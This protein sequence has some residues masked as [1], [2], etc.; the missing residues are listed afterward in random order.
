MKVAVLGGGGCF[1]LNFVSHLDDNSIEHFGIGRSLEK[2]PAFWQVSHHYRYRALHLSFNREAICAVLDTER[3]DIVV[4]F[5]AQGEG[6]ASFGENAPDYFQTNTVALV[7]LVCEL[8]KRNYLKRFIQIGSSEVYG[9]P[10]APARET[11]LLNPTSP[12]SV[13]KAAFDL[14]LQSM[15]K[16]AAFP[17]N[18]IRPSNCYVEGQQLYRVIPKTMVCALK[19]EKLEL[20]GGG[21]AQKSYLHASDLS[22]AVLDVIYKAPAGSIYNV[23]PAEPI[24]IRD[25]VEMIAQTV[26]IPFAELVKEAPDRIG[27]DA[28]YHLNCDAIKALGW[29]QTISLAEGL[30]AMYEWVKRYPQLLTMPTGYQHRV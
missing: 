11:D 20:H 18:I 28:K 24:T 8:R 10:D 5:A 2:D 22:R 23:G 3:P 25:L 16:T 29:S 14:Y 1:A 17:M 27:Q 7:R 12:Y 6:A 26:G 15:W 4:N 9:S 21:V 13:S 30:Q 19:G